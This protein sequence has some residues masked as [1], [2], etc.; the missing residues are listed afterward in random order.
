[1]IH[2]E[3]RANHIS[4]FSSFRRGWNHYKCNLIR[5]N[6]SISLCWMRIGFERKTM[7]CVHKSLLANTI[8]NNSHFL[9]VTSLTVPMFDIITLDF[10]DNISI[11]QLIARVTSSSSSYIYIFHPVN[12]CNNAFNKICLWQK[13]SRYAPK[14]NQSQCLEQWRMQKTIYYSLLA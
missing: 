10:S 5:F 12:I 7:K 11:Q 2:S 1:M 4:R 3:Q 9:S 13:I 6:S 8:K 14:A